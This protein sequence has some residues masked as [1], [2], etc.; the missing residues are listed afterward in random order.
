MNSDQLNKFTSIFNLQLP[1]SILEKIIVLFLD[2]NCDNWNID[3]LDYY[4]QN[5]PVEC[6]FY[7]DFFYIP[8]FSRYV[9][10]REGVMLVVKT[11][12]MKIWTKTSGNH[13]KKY[14]RWLQSI[15]WCL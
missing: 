2:G 10:N 14:K 5:G 8:K 12:R 9:I 4:F 13:K 1:S 6:P 11:G 7:K 15:T 3:N